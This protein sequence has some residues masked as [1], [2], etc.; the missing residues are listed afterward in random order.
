MTPFVGRS[1]IV[2]NRKSFDILS[3]VANSPF[4]DG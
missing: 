4:Q 1:T 2:F 3:E